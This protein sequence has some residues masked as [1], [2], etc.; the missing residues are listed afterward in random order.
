MMKDVSESGEQGWKSDPRPFKGISGKSGL[1]EG[2]YMDYVW[3]PNLGS[4]CSDRSRI[5]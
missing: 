2:V 4:D 5:P 3:N 1:T